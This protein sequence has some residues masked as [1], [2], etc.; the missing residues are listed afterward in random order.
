MRCK[1]HGVKILCVCVCVAWCVE[2][3]GGGGG[4][5]G[6]REGEELEDELKDKIK[7]W[8]TH[9]EQDKMVWTSLENEEIPRKSFQTRNYKKIAHEPIKL[10][11]GT[12]G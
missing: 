7:I 11:T 5:R 8:L 10:K 4:G 2:T 3:G 12:T 1:L 6:G 9:N